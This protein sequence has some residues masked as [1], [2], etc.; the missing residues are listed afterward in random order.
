MIV[1][2]PWCLGR[3][4]IAIVVSMVGCGPEVGVGMSGSGSGSGSAV[5]D[6]S[7]GESELETGA[8]MAW[9]EEFHGTYF[10]EHGLSLGIPG[11]YVAGLSNLELR[12]DGLFVTHLSCA[13]E[14][15]DLH[16]QFS[17]DYEGAEAHIRPREGDSVV[18]WRGGPMAAELILRPG[19]TC[20]TMDAE[21]VDPAIGTTYP[22]PWLLH[23]GALVITD[24]C[25]DNDDV[26]AF[27]LDPDVPTDCDPGG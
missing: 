7:L 1:R 16:D 2:A 3:L 19:A 4:G 26:W 24:E 27:D 21:L 8:P 15:N 9:P 12:P 5:T 14:D 23:R 20:R 10:F 17:V 6:E 25:G 22:T 18:M 13:G 11:M